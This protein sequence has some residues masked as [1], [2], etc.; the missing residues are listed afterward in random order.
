MMAHNHV[1]EIAQI[2]H[3]NHTGNAWCDGEAL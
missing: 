3:I 2:F 1:V